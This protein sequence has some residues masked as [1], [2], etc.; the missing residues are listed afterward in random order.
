M[1]LLNTSGVSNMPEKTEMKAGPVIGKARDHIFE[2]IID[3]TITTST[4]GKIV[5][6][7]GFRKFSLLARFEGQPNAKIRFEVNQN[8]LLVAQE[9]FNLN[10]GGWYNF[11]KVYEVFAPSIGVVIYEFPP[12]VK[13]K[14]SI[15]AGY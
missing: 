6:V 11:S 8:N 15:Y 5:N 1:L 13:T 7:A 4:P 12:G 9:I 10:A 3:A 2:T 14:M